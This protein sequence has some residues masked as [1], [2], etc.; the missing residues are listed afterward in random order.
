MTYPHGYAIPPTGL[1][2]T[3]EPGIAPLLRWLEPM[4]RSIVLS[5]L[6]ATAGTPAE[7][8]RALVEDLRERL[9]VPVEI[10]WEHDAHL[11][12]F[13]AVFRY[14]RETLSLVEARCS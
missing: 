9:R 12:A 10:G 1:R 6:D 14:P 7:R 11:A 2:A 3:P 13:E 5:L 8:C 4:H